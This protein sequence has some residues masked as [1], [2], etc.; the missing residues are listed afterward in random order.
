MSQKSFAQVEY[1][2]TFPGSDSDQSKVVEIQDVQLFDDQIQQS[3]KKTK[4]I[5]DQK[6]FE[7][8]NE[9]TKTMLQKSY[10]AEKK[11]QDPSLSDLKIPIEEALASHDRQK[12][13][14]GSVLVLKGE[15]V[16]YENDFGYRDTGRNTKFSS[17]TVVSLGE[18]SRIFTAMAAY[19]AKSMFGLDFEDPINKYIGEIPLAYKSV[20]IKHLLS[21]TSGI[22][23][24]AINCSLTQRP[25]NLDVVNWLKQAPLDFTPGLKHQI[26]NSNYIILATIIERVSSKYFP[27]FVD[28][29]I[30]I[31]S[32]MSYSKVYNK[33]EPS[34]L[35]RAIS[36][37]DFPYFSK[38]SPFQCS[39]AYGDTGVYS[40][41][42]DLKKW[43]VA[44]RKGTLF[45]AATQK[46]YFTLARFGDSRSIN[47]AN[48]WSYYFNEDL[49]LEAYDS[50]NSFHSLIEY[51]PFK[52]L[53]V[54]VLGNYEGMRARA[55]AKSLLQKYSL[56]GLES[57]RK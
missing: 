14:G 39:Y 41:I 8:F 24:F 44:M 13:P 47:Y 51:L 27:R 54:L 17:D 6:K 55:I 38:K 1:L 57:Y 49:T 42:S 35:N 37:G 26:S 15:Q 2:K 23:E 50:S 36:Y 4:N 10:F 56:I 28:E 21:Q 40:S 48:G 12:G 43:I 19:I 34:I 11:W 18:T 30:F 32:G 53:Y 29:Y 20:K 25:T 5:F 45:D 16:L 22:P 46:Q 52:D 9:K 7:Y 3:V 31:P 33:N